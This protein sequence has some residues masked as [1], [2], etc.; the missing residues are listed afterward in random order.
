[1]HIAALIVGC[2][3]VGSMLWDVFETVA[4]PRTALRK[5]R[6][7]RGFY[8]GTWRPWVAIARRM[9][10]DSSRESF[11][12]LYGP[13]SIFGL[14]T[15]WAGGLVMGFALLQWSQRTLVSD[16]PGDSRLFDLVYFSGSTL[17]TLGVGDLSP[18]NE[19][20]RVL[21]VA[22]AGIGLTL[23]TMVLSYLPVLYGSFSRREAR[24]T[25]LDIRAGTPPAAAELL[26]SLVTTGDPAALNEFL[27]EWEYWCSE[28]LESHISYPPVAYFRSQHRRQSWIAALATVLDLSALLKVG[29]AGRG[30]WRADQTFAIARHAAVDLAQI[31]GGPLDWTVDRLPREELAALRRDLGDAGLT[32]SL[33]ANAQLAEL[34]RSYEPYVA[35]LSTRLMMATP[36]W[37]H[38]TAVR[39]NWK[40]DPLRDGGADL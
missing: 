11:L 40:T 34:R 26:R 20:G 22:E 12:A 36:P 39:Y 17:F 6:L 35:A 25:L 24:L 7:A 8:R 37:R 31:L 3:I 10:S 30:A 16:L 9:R 13:L 1:M 32:L 5:V 2:L 29:V 18:D 21:T 38:A 4:L 14:L 15:V 19:A 28:L 23:L 27:K 33:E